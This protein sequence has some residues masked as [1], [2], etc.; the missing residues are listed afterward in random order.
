MKTYCQI[1]FTKRL[2]FYGQLPSMSNADVS[3]LYDRSQNDMDF[4]SAVDRSPLQRWVLTKN[5]ISVCWGLIHLAAAICSYLANDPSK[6][7]ISICMD[8]WTYQQQVGSIVPI[9]TALFAASLHSE[10]AYSEGIPQVITYWFQQAITNRLIHLKKEVNIE[11][12]MLFKWNYFMYI[13]IN[14]TANAVY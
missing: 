4:S 5:H 1:L 2:K 9:F 11:V 10:D 14:A 7:S 8:F 6:K 13:V 3:S 12:S